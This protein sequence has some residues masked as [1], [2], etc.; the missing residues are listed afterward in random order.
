MEKKEGK[1]LVTSRVD[2]DYTGKKP[3][4]KFGY[5]YKDKNKAARAQGGLL[6]ITILIWFIIGAIPLLVFVYADYYENYMGVDYPKECGNFTLDDLSYTGY[7]ENSSY[8]YSYKKVDGFNVTCDNQIHV[9]DFRIYGG[10]FTEYDN[11]NHNL[12]T[13]N[14]LLYFLL[15]WFYTSLFV[16][17]Y[18]NKNLITRFLIKKKWYQRWLPKANADGVLWKRRSK[19]YRKFKSKDVLDNIIVV[20]EFSNVELDYKTKGEFSK[21]LVKIKIREHRNRK[22]NIKSKKIGK[23]KMEICKWYA[24]F[25]FKQKPKDGYLEVIYQ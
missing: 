1:H 15:F 24:I 23:E 25:Y 7:F 8:N 22:I 2:V 3:T 14:Y 6:S 18:I 5:P 17:S 21:Y 4:I 11:R 10:Y 16:A 12:F 13:N 20:P 19:R 9:I